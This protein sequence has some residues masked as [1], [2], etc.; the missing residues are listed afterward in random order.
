MLGDRTL[1]TAHGFMHDVAGRLANR[2]QLTTD[3][4]RPYLAAGEDTFGED[5]DY[6]M[7]IKVSGADNDPEKRYHSLRSAICCPDLRSE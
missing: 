5:I 3:G 6:A 4:H 7:L 1:A 2:V